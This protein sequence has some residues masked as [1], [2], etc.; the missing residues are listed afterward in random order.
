M[1]QERISVGIIISTH[2]VQGEVKVLPLTDFPERFRPGTRLILEQEGAAGRALPVTVTRSRPGKGSLILKLAELNDVD[3]AGA[4]RG[5]TLKVEPWEVEPLPA[6]HYYIYQLVG[7]RVYTT[8]GDC[9][10][11]LIDVLTTGA[12]DVY[13]VRDN[14]AGDAREV[15]I[16]ALKQVVRRIDLTAREIQ[17]ELPPGLLD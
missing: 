9:L 2:G 15:L 3:R 4:V 5:A 1:V 10:G 16:P 12:N 17:V 14:D 7:C 11:T 6:G 8:G 13:V